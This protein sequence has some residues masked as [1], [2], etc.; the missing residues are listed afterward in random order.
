MGK[1]KYTYFLNGVEISRSE[2][3]DKLARYYCNDVY[4]NGFNAISVPNYQKAEN[5]I[6]RMQQTN[7]R[8]ILTGNKF[9]KIQKEKRY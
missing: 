7:L 1:N 4:G 3:K 6:R 2:F 8:G 9:F 5:Q